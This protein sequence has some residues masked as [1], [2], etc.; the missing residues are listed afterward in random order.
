MHWYVV[1]ISIV[2]R[3]TIEMRMKWSYYILYYFSFSHYFCFD[4]LIIVLGFPLPIDAF[5]DCIPT[6]TSVQE[7]G[8]LFRIAQTEIFCD[9][10]NVKVFVVWFSQM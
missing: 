3:Q 8:L 5:C 9:M 6:H 1:F 7:L 10:G 4:Y 2:W